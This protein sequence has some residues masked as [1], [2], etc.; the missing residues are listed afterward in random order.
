MEQNLVVVNGPGVITSFTIPKK[1]IVAPCVSEDENITKESSQNLI[2]HYAYSHFHV[3]KEDCNF[4]Q[5]QAHSQY[6]SKLEAHLNNK[7]QNG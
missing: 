7:I 1:R 3:F 6:F 2:I 4:Q 5:D